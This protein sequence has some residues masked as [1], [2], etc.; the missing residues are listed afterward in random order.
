MEEQKIYNKF[1]QVTA[2]GIQRIMVLHTR[3]VTLYQ[4]FFSLMTASYSFIS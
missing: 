3:N 2:S 4:I 1:N